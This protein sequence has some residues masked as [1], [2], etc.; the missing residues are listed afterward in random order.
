ME[1]KNLQM[2]LL[3]TQ[4]DGRPSERGMRE[5]ISRMKQSA[6]QT[7]GGIRGLEDALRKF[8]SGVNIS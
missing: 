4:D 2:E 3:K 6:N 1:Q 7:S 5:T 8:G